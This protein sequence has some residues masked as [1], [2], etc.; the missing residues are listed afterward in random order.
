MREVRGRQDSRCDVRGRHNAYGEQRGRQ[1][2][3]NTEGRAHFRPDPWDAA[4][5]SGTECRAQESRDQLEIE[6]VVKSDSAGGRVNF[7]RKLE[8]VQFTSHDTSAI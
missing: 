7:G 4:L 5:R 2:L 8:P 1:A 3:L 6:D